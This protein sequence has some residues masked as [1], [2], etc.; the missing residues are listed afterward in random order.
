LHDAKTTAMQSAEK[1]R[2]CFIEIDLKFVYFGSNFIRSVSDWGDTCPSLVP[3]LITFTYNPMDGANQVSKTEVSLASHDERLSGPFSMLMEVSL[4][5]SVAN[6][7]A[8]V[9]VLSAPTNVRT[10]D[11]KICIPASIVSTPGSEIG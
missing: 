4:I 11:R 3:L 1:I 5:C 8:D 7:P 9:I 2:I 6:V 10:S